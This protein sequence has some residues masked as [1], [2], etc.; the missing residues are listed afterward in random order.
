MKVR[1]NGFEMYYED[2]GKGVLVVFIHVLGGESRPDWSFFIPDLSKEIRCITLD[3]RGHGRS[4]KPDHP[5]TQSMFADDVAALL[6]YLK[7]DEA[8]YCGVSLGGGIAMKSALNHPEKV[9]GLVLV[10]TDA[11]MPA[12]TTEVLN[13][14]GQAA[15]KGVDAYIKEAMETYFHPMFVKRHKDDVDVFVESMRTREWVAETFARVDQGYALEPYDIR[16][17]LRNI[18]VP[19]LIIHGREDKIIPYEEAVLIHKEIKNSK[20]VPIPFASHLSAIERRDFFIDLLL[21]FVEEQ[22]GFKR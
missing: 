1:V 15:E 21:Y 6:D 14:L 7:I 2:I 4:E 18:R 20:L 9:R 8:Y 13:K 19:T 16:E 10:D 11:R 17:E 3:L 5:Y 12:E 22:E